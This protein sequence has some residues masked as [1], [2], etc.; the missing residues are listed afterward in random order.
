MGDNIMTHPL[1]A[2]LLESSD[3]DHA[4]KNEAFGVVAQL[5]TASAAHLTDYIV[6]Y[7]QVAQVAPGREK[8]IVGVLCKAGILSPVEI[9]G[10]KLLKIV[11]DP[12][13]LHNR[14]REEVMTDRNR[15]ADKRKPEL[16]YPVRVRDGDICRWCKKTVDW[17]DRRSGRAA[18]YDSLNGHKDSTPDTIVISCKSCNSKRKDGVELELQDPPAQEGL[19]YSKETCELINNSNWARD[20]GVHLLEYQTELDFESTTDLRQQACGEAAAG[21]GR[22]APTTH[23]AA[24]GDV[25]GFDDPLE[26]APEWVK[27]AVEV[28]EAPFSRRVCGEAAAGDGRAAPTTHSEAVDVEAPNLC[29][30]TRSGSNA[31]SD[32]GSRYRFKSRSSSGSRSDLDRMG[33]GTGSVG[34]GRVGSGR[35]TR[36]RRRGHRGK[37]HG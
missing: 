10:R 37:K 21:D 8:L 29:E 24:P 9:E 35:E 15:S 18:T 22:A 12:E 25:A 27:E 19:R 1:M 36:R 7:G 13:Y 30:T 5:T 4:I 23:R 31:D 17:K 14:L 6:E 32:P 2:R 33:D 3:F 11:D 16:L 26:D 28:V 34:S 20:N